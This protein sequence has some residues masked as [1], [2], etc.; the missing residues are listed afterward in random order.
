[1][2]KK[3][4]SRQS[5]IWDTYLPYLLFAYREVPQAST[6]FSPFELLYGRKVKGPLGLVY[7]NRYGRYVSQIFGCLDTYFFN[8]VF[9]TPLK[10]STNPYTLDDTE[11][12][13]TSSLTSM[14]Q[15]HF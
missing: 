15:N 4:V 14:Q 11:W 7:D 1:M 9:R 5:N 6:G 3:Y 2:L 13:S 10:R 12:F 8:M